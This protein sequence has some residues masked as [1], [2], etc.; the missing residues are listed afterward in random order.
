MKALKITLFVLLAIVVLPI[1]AA[2]LGENKLKNIRVN[3]TA[4]ESRHAEKHYAIGYRV[5]YANQFS[6]SCGEFATTQAQK[7]L[8]GS[9]TSILT[10]LLHR[11]NNNAR[12]GYNEAHIQAKQDIRNSSMT[13]EE[14]CAVHDEKLLTLTKK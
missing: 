12:A 2:T 10:R 1:L 13:V 11:Q 14:Y 7:I 6:V 5:G 3:H 9:D 4:Y 8:D